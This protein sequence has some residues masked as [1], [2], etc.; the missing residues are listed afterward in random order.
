[1]GGI[2]GCQALKNLNTHW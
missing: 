2:E 1:M